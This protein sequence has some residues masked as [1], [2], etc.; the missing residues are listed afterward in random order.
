MQRPQ[1]RQPGASTEA[2]LR[3]QVAEVRRLE[4]TGAAP[5]DIAERKRLILRLQ[6]RLAYAVRDLL[7]GQRTSPTT[8]DS[9]TNLREE[10]KT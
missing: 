2:H 6:E 10:E 7:G 3:R 5:E 8:I 1:A 9:S 4:R